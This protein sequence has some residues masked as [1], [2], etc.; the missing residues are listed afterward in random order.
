MKKLRTISRVMVTHEDKILLVRNR[1]ANFWYPPGGGWEFEEETIAECAAREVAEETGYKVTIKDL[2]WVREFREGEEKVFLETFWRAS[3]SP[4]NTQS[5]DTLSDHIDLD[6]NGIVDEARW[7]TSDDI[8]D[9][10]VLPEIIKTF[11]SLSPETTT[12]Y[13]G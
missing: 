7:F 13:L 12:T 1:D 5:T 8:Q 6:P 2:V 9:M 10:K 11:A 4:E 3:L